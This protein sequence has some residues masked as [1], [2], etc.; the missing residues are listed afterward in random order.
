MDNNEIKCFVDELN[1]KDFIFLE[2]DN[3][4]IKT[5]NIRKIEIEDVINYERF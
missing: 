3:V 5:E 2:D 1:D 4:I